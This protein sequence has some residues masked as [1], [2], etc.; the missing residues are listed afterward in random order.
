MSRDPIRISNALADVR[1]EI[2]GQPAHRAADQE[3]ADDFKI[4]M[5]LLGG[6]HARVEM[7]PPI[8]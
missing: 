2:R 1:C 5:E 8:S 6:K 3:I 7:M 4:G